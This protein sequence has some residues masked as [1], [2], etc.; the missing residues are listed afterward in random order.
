VPGGE[1]A[2]PPGAELHR[3]VVCA[4]ETDDLICEACRARIRGEALERKLAEERQ[5]RRSAP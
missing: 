5:G 1:A 3:C 2:A 4:R